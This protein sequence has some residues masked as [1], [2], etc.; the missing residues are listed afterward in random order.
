MWQTHKPAVIRGDHITRDFTDLSA[1]K[2][3][4]AWEKIAAVLVAAWI[5]DRGMASKEKPGVAALNRPA[6]HHRRPEVGAEEVR[7]RARGRSRLARGARW[8]RG[9]ARALPGDRGDRDPMPLGRPAQQRAGH[10]RQVQ[11]ADRSRTGTPGD[12]HRPL[13]ETPF[14]RADHQ[15]IGRIL[16]Q[17]QRAARRF[18][19]RLAEDD[20]PAGLRLEVEVDAAFDDWAALSEG[21]YLLRSNITDWSDEQLLRSAKRP[22]K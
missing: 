16:Q 17:N 13:Q 21:A 1:G 14:W 5:A 15:Q 18:K 8:R 10:A 4:V 12:P 9:Q 22:G 20:G 2:E 6:L 11:Q 7:R 3:R 19:A